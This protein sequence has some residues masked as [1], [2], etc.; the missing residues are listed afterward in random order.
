MGSNLTEAFS[1]PESMLC[2]CW[3]AIT[4]FSFSAKVWGHVL[5]DG[6]SEIKF[7]D[8]AFEQLV[9]APDRKQLIHAMVKHSEGVF[10]DIIS[11][12]GGGSIFL[13][14]GPPGMYFVVMRY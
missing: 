5:V 14:H 9:L 1:V 7:D 4:G 8:K 11:G 12:K 13:L 6:L 3:P 10:K 2:L